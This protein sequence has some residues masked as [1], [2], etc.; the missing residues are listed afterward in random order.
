[1]PSII[2]IVALGLVAAWTDVV[3]VVPRPPDTL[4]ILGPDAPSDVLAMPSRTKEVLSVAGPVRLRLQLFGIVKRGGRR[5]QRPGEVTMSVDDGPLQVLE[6]TPTT[7]VGRTVNKHPLWLVTPMREVELSLDEGPHVITLAPSNAVTLGYGLRVE[8]ETIQPATP[9]APPA[10]AVAGGDVMP[11]PEP[12]PAPPEV[13][14]PV[15]RGFAILGAAPPRLRVLGAQGAAELL[16]V[17]SEDALRL[18]VTG[19]GVLVLEVHANRDPQR[20]ETLQPIVVGIL[21]DDVLVQTVALDQPASELGHVEGATFSLAK[22]VTVRLPI[23]AGSHEL[24]LS[25]SDNATHGIT[26]RPLF[27]HLAPGEPA[28]LTSESAREGDLMAQGQGAHGSLG[29]GLLAG[30]FVPWNVGSVGFGA[31]L[32]GRMHVPALGKHLLLG[33][34]GGVSFASHERDV[35][36]LR[37]RDGRA[38][39]ATSLLNLPIIADLRWHALISPPFALELGAGAGLLLSRVTSTALGASS[40]SGLAASAVG[41]LLMGASMPLG[42]G[43]FLVRGA[44]LAGSFVAASGVRRFGPGGLLLLAGYAFGS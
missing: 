16:H 37:A 43:R 36:D 12:P 9:N 2:S 5:P 25:L 41:E 14:A 6:L 13:V 20:P 4:A 11:P 29:V 40:D 1:M 8:V 35:A 15:G 26:V 22:R 33:V 32:E 44:L 17:S 34:S 21:L 28:L 18:R 42:P 27:E 38:Q 39:L 31:T 23:K 3:E 24:D 10:D 30:A 19:P 7:G